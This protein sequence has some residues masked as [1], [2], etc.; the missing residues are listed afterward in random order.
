M[1]ATAVA[2]S[3]LAFIKYWGVIDPVL[4]LPA[5]N[6]ISM[7]LSGLLT[8]TTVEFNDSFNE[9]DILINGEYNKSESDRVT[10]HLNRIRALAKIGAK[11][12]VVSKNN[13]PASTGLSSSASG[14]AALTAASAAA[15]SL[16]L[17][18][19]RL[20]ILARLGSGSACRSVPDG[21]TEWVAGKTSDDSYGL[22]LYPPDYWNIVDLV[23][24]ISS[25]KKEIPT[26][27]GHGLASTSPFFQ[28][29]QN[30]LP[31][32]IKDLKKYLS[33]KDFNK[34][35]HLVEAE[36]LELHAIMLTSNPSL[37]Y[38]RPETVLLIRKVQ[39]WR[40]E[41][42]EVFFSLNTGQDV[43]LLCQ[44]K[45]VKSLKDLVARIPQVKKTILNYPSNGVRLVD[46]HLF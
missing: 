16:N 38:L 1:K 29:R 10:I 31:N 22:S 3:N 35:G 41:G 43:H 27:Q 40:K 36:A 23:A 37:F 20:S 19:R 12:R 6:S 33:E 2:P 9:D 7:N 44:E 21:V 17:S 11:A 24:I 13:F 28:V 4:R 32:K 14:L 30:L 18:I 45:D 15:C 34:F 42:L 46:N 25:E 5:N 26:T 8:T 39:N